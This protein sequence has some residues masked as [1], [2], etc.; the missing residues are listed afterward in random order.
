AAA[1]ATAQAT[2]T[3]A[4]SATAQ[5]TATAAASATAVPPR[6]AATVVRVP[7]GSTLDVRIEGV[8]VAVA[9][10]GAKAPSM[11][12][13]CGAEA[14]ARN[15]DLAGTAVFLEADARYE[16]DDR[17]FR[18]FYAYRPDGLFIDGTL[19]QEGLARAV[20][21]DGRHG[22]L[23]AALEAEAQAAKRGCLWSTETIPGGA[24]P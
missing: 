12:T 13:L 15:R 23:L 24:Q 19:V 1:S 18:L 8:R 16:L 14:H 5:A 6:V 17:G 4:A 20:R 9:Y 3:A 22:A 7:D 21:L 2:A 11:N 10:L